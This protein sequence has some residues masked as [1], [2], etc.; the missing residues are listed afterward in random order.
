L[1]NL[2]FFRTNLH[3]MDC[4]GRDGLGGLIFLDNMTLNRL[5]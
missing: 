2:D 5:S 4:D 3:K 1:K